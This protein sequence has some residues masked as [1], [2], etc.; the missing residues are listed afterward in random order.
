MNWNWIKNIAV[1]SMG[2]LLLS[3][4]N[5]EGSQEENPQKKV[6]V[7]GVQSE[8]DAVENVDFPATVTVGDKEVTIE[9]K[10]MRILPLSLDGAEI[11][12][13][14]VDPARVLAISKSVVDPMLST[15][16]DAG[17]LI[18]DR[19]ASATNIDPE[20]ILAYDTD[21]L[22]LT[23]MHGQEADA[24][25]ILSQAGIPILS[26][27]T[28]KTLQEFMDN[29]NVIGHA[30]GEK[31]KAQR[32]V[33]DMQKEI[34]SIQA[35]IPADAVAPTVLVLS[36]VGPGTGPYV[37]GPTNISYDIIKLAG[38]TPAVDLIGLDRTTKAEVEQVIK[39]DPNHLFLLD[40]QG[41]GEE[42]YKELMES[43]GWNTLQAVRNNNITI[44]EVKYLMNPNKDNIYGLNIM[45]DTIHG[46]TK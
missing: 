21:L 45:T 40:W 38:G 10:P 5:A 19:F 20:Q 14:L 30:V 3:A 44:M 31:E 9:E 2:T 42:T 23:K 28:T 39:M 41:N 29:I 15:H 33:A 35:K 22:L 18:K 43:P 12:L 1:I 4:C 46:L 13:D 25:Q 34:E 27:E 16:S 17:E 11:I 6:E 24:D 32:M 36:E 7:S 26:F 8:A 37:L